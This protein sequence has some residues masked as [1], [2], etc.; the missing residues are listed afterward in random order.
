MKIEMTHEEVLKLLHDGYDIKGF[1]SNSSP[2]WHKNA[3]RLW[4][5]MWLRCYDPTSDNYQYYK[6]C[7]IHEKF[8]LFSNFLKWLESEPRFEDF[9]RTC[10]NIRWCIDKD[11]KCSRNRNY[12]PEYM[13][14][15]TQSI[16]SKERNKRLGIP[17]GNR[18]NRIP[19]I[20]ICDDSILLFKSYAH[21]K[22]YK[23]YRSSIKKCYKNNKRYKGYKWYRLNYKHGKVLRFKFHQG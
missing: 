17:D 22:E 1:I 4:R 14:L 16:N 23:F 19:I 11:M 2:K 13:T 3:R 21:A 6:D 7:K 12:Y 9:K 8:R 18:N 15:T 5:K 20:G 10:G